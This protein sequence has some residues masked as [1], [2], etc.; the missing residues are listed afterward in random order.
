MIRRFL[1]PVYTAC[2]VLA[3]L[4]LLSIA[5]IVIAQIIGRLF[6]L[7]IP[8]ADDFA[9]YAL[10]AST[11]LG[12]AYTF[13]AGGHIRVSIFTNLIEP[14]KRRQVELLVLAMGAVLMGYFTWYSYDMVITSYR[15]RTVSSGLIATP[16]W[17][18]QACILLGSLMMTVSMID[19]FVRVLRGGRP[20]Y[21][22]QESNAIA[23]E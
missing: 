21:E 15:F 18:P 5:V 7:L 4:S 10:Q 17:I 1:D 20:L 16:L 6:D 9:G 2:G 3:C 14:V 8:S 23:R 22:E 19:E 11:F 13:R 12:L